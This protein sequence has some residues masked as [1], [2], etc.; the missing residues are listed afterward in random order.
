M[1]TKAEQFT[2][3]HDGVTIPIS[4]GGEG[5]PLV[6]C[7]GLTSTRTEL[8]ELIELLRRD[9]DVVTFDL[10]GHGLSSA[11]DRYSFDAFLGDLVAVMAEL[12]RRG[13]PTAPILAGHSYGADLI[14]HYAAE[15]PHT[16]GELIVIDGA[17]PVPAP[18]IT[19][20]D[21]PEF[22]AMWENLATWQETVR[23]TPR[24]V[25]L[26]P[27]QILDLNLE[28]DVIRSGID[29]EIDVVGSG[30]IDRYRKIDC[31][32]RL[33]VATTMAGDSVEGRAPRHNRLWRAGIE[34]LVRERPHIATSWLDA[35]HALVV[36][37][38]PAIAQLVRDVQTPAGQPSSRAAPRSGR[39]DRC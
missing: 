1:T 36:T 18:F 13:L 25:L 33:I 21:L 29:L 4:R 6:L 5:R 2:V 7:P 32:I 26:T 8:H 9:F 19:E 12:A 14:V 34:R 28:L 35:T 30:I 15:Y 17:V 22:R 27:Q 37:H 23:G 3:R 24:Q 20:A 16:V 39:L 10:R 31:P 11:A 38:A